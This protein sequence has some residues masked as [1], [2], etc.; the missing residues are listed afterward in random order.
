MLRKRTKQNSL[1]SLIE[2]DRYYLMNLTVPDLYP[3]E[4]MWQVFKYSVRNS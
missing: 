4:I 1:N 2:E 3:I